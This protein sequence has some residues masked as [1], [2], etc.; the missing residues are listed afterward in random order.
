MPEMDSTEFVQRRLYNNH[1]HDGTPNGGP[2]IPPD[3][4][5]NL[6]ISGKL[7]VGTTSPTVALDVVGSAK[8]STGI[9]CN[10]SAT[11][12]GSG[13]LGEYKLQANNFTNWNT[14]T[15]SSGAVYKTIVTNAGSDMTVTLSA[16]IWN[17]FL[18]VTF[19]NGGS[20][21]NIYTIGIGISTDS[22]ASSFSDI[23][24]LG[25]SGSNF[26]YVPCFDL[27]QARNG[28]CGNSLSKIIAIS[29]STT[30]YP[31]V[32]IESPS[33]VSFNIRAQLYAV[34]IQ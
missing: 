29:S 32:R 5:V 4:F 24:E 20:A 18:N 21:V 19:W 17:V 10:G 8:I 11:Q 23:V 15:A 16:G 22:G 1:R 27:T 3:Y 6:Y 31:K 33:G 14:I 9:V 26:T 30:I 34:N 7:G 12:Y 13:K 25:S 2:K 28:T